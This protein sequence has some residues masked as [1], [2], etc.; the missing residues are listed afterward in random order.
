MIK[1]LLVEE[2]AML[3]ESLA[4]IIGGQADMEIAGTANDVSKALQL[5]RELKPDLLLMNAEIEK[6]NAI[7]VAALI[8]KELPEVKIVIMIASQ[9]ITL[10]DEARKAGA[11]SLIYKTSSFKDLSFV[12]RCSMEGTGYY[13]VGLIK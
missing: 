11:H 3:R 5:C 10:E 13:Q 9:N 2:Q 7:N 8:R 6:T 12:I 4:C 1:I